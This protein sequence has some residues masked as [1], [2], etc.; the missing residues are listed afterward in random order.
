MRVDIFAVDIKNGGRKFYDVR[1]DADCIRYAVDIPDAYD[2]VRG[3]DG[4]ISLTREGH[5]YALNDILTPNDINQPVFN[6]AYITGDRDAPCVTLEVLPS[7]EREP[8]SWPE[9]VD[10]LISQFGAMGLRFSI[11]PE[12]GQLVIRPEDGTARFVRKMYP[13]ELEAIRY[14][15]KN[16]WNQRRYAELARQQSTEKAAEKDGE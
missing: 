14:G 16:R 5:E 3:D 9:G 7:G 8:L 4:H 13:K 10:D 11:H 12:T 15:L 6:W 2:P 1:P